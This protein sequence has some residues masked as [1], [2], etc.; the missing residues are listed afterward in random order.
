MSSETKPENGPTGFH[1]QHE[2]HAKLRE[3]IQTYETEQSLCKYISL[4][5]SPPLS[6]AMQP[7]QRWRDENEPIMQDAKAS[8]SQRQVMSEPK[9][10]KRE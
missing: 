8:P 9:K 4:I 2:E 5:I 7:V 3:T 6:H 10:W 1:L